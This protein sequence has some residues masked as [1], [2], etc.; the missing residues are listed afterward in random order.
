MSVARTLRGAADPGN[1]EDIRQPL[2]ALRDAAR[3]VGEAWSGSA[4]GYHARVYYAD[5]E[6]T[7]PGMG[8]SS[9][10]GFE[11]AFSNFTRGDW[12]EYAQQDVVA[13]IWGRAGNPDLTAVRARANAARN[14]LDEQKSELQSILSAFL[15]QHEDPLLEELKETGMKVLAGTEDQFRRAAIPTGNLMSRDMRAITDGVHI[16]PHLAVFAEVLALESPF[17]SCTELAAIAQ[18]AA[19]HIERL[20][21]GRRTPTRPIGTAV[22]IG[23]GRSLLWRELK[24]F[25]HERLG[26][27]WDEF[28]RVPVAGTSNAARL[29][30]MLDSAA[31]AFLVLT[32]EDEQA[33]GALHARQNVVHEA[34]LFQGRLGFHRAIV[35]LEEGCEQFSNIE[36]LGQ[37]R[38]PAGRI[39]AAFEEIRLVLE[40]EGLLKD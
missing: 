12:R 37:I 21:S 31:I 2:D 11:E 9:E 28:N 32:A 40:R 13:E 36:G 4:L 1:H 23:H 33:D 18:R 3:N 29:V 5:L 16:A 24:D 7:P 19:T 27:P 6:P 35:L 30:E 20:E 15:A 22:F 10:W 17:A 14:T 34:G 39:N 25:I 26:L 38:F 8:F